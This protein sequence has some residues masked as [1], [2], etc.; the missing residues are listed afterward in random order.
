MQTHEK[1]KPIFELAAANSAE[2]L[3]TPLPVPCDVILLVKEQQFSGLTFRR[4]EIKKKLKKGGAAAASEEEEE[5]EGGAGEETD[6]AGSAA[7]ADVTMDEPGDEP[8]DGAAA[9]AAA[10]ATTATAALPIEP[11]VVSYMA[12]G[13]DGPQA[14]GG[15][16]DTS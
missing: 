5:E 2:P 14:Q 16:G 12:A 4:P 7:A 8:G 3:G 15:G 10:A 1:L 9:A 6:A 13:S 11:E